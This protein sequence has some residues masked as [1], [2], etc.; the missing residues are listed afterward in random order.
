MGLCLVLCQLG[1]NKFLTKIYKIQKFHFI[2]PQ[3]SCKDYMQ[4]KEIH[5]DWLQEYIHKQIPSKMKRQH[6]YCKILI[7]CFSSKINSSFFKMFVFLQ[8]KY[9]K[10]CKKQS[11]SLNFLLLFRN[12]CCWTIDK[13]MECVP[14]IDVALHS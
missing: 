4:E 1:E 12:R 8:F 14:N 10:S 13:K 3:R 7:L 6:D 9:R 5:I 11:I 2:D